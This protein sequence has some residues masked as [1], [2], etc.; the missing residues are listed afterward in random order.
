MNRLLCLLL[1]LN[2]GCQLSWSHVALKYPPARKYDLD[3]LDNIRTP[4]PCG[5]PQGEDRTTIVA[6]STFN[7]T[8]HLAYPH[9]GGYRL[10]L[11]TDEGRP[12]MNLT[13]SSGPNAFLR[14]DA[15]AQRHQIQ[16]PRNI[17]CKGC[18]IRLE[19]EAAEWSNNYLFWSCADV[20]I[21]HEDEHKEDCFGNGVFRHGECVCKKLYSGPRCQYKDE[22]WE[23]K[24]C[25]PNGKCI[26]VKA[27]TFPEK[28]CFCQMGWFGEGCGKAYSIETTDID[29]SK[30]RSYNLSSDFQIYWKVYPSLGEI[31]IVAKVKT[32]SYVGIGWRPKVLTS[33]C[34]AFPII[35]DHVVFDS[36]IEGV[37]VGVAE[38][39]PLPEPETQPP[40]LQST[41]KPVSEPVYQEDRSRTIIETSPNETFIAHKGNVTEVD[42]S[43]DDAAVM[44]ETASEP[45]PEYFSRNYSGTTEGRGF[46]TIKEPFAEPTVTDKTPLKEEITEATAESNRHPITLEVS[47]PTVNVLTNESNPHDHS[48]FD[49]TQ[50]SEVNYGSEHQTSEGL[51]EYVHDPDT[52]QSTYRSSGKPR[53]KR[54]VL[55]STT[56]FINETTTIR[57]DASVEPETVAEPNV[58]QTGRQGKTAI[59]N[60]FPYQ[61]FEPEPT[62]EGKPE[63]FVAPKSKSS[64]LNYNKSYKPGPYTPKADFHAMDCTDVIIGTAYGNYSRIFDYYT[65]DRSTPRVDKFWGGSDSLTAATGFERGGYTT[66]IFRRK[67][68]ATEI[69][70]H[71][72]VNGPMH[73][74]WAKGQEP[75]SYI[76]SPLSGL[77]TGKPSIPEFYHRDELK[78][79]GHGSQRGVETIDFLNNQQVDKPVDEAKGEF[80]YP[81]SCTVDDCE[82]RAT[83]E[84]ISS[85]DLILFTVSTNNS[86]KWTGIG[87]SDDTKMPNTDA[88]LGWVDESGRTFVMDVWINRYEPPTLDNIQN[89]ENFKGSKK[90]GRVSLS[91]TRKRN[92]GDSQ[93]DLAFTDSNCLYMIYPFN[94]GVFNAVSKK[95][96]QHDSK[97]I[98]SSSKICI[99]GNGVAG[100][101]GMD[102]S[103]NLNLYYWLFI[104]YYIL[105]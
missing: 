58:N 99:R 104:F 37:G 38:P 26:D 50:H 105:F 36:T 95:I 23:D 47:A 74:I 17:S 52:Y 98:V 40:P 22:C 9:R 41:S 86:D 48:Y 6:G 77:E 79:H 14:E 32:T 103:L 63:P 44:E 60:E 29:L 5:M 85:Q 15:T 66:I 75:G 69:T 2:G 4:G 67:L 21:V 31:E 87:F 1:L 70:D 20:N 91:F 28:Q 90:N 33:A 24:D 73:V 71:S 30:H 35:E 54:E 11:L 12:W 7:V 102:I 10:Q 81:S 25:G 100:S 59:S 39:E 49:D 18:S 84:F 43:A 101:G 68:E 55:A 62:A 46:A 8:W 34:K 93:Q 89:V 76:H 65:R 61:E 82:Y 94:G 88:I 27:T 56:D 64:E 42:L 78:Y 51:V 3:F 80:K 19:R 92:T 45:K 72:F 97:P 57:D 96:R 83:W 53:E 13:P 16:I